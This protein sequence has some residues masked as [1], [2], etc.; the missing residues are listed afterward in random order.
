[1]LCTLCLSPFVREFQVK[2]TQCSNCGL[3]AKSADLL[4]DRMSEKS[5][6]EFHQN[7]L[8]DPGYLKFVDPMVS[9]VE[10]NCLQS[11]ELL[12]FGSGPDSAVGHRLRSLGFRV[13]KYDPFFHPVKASLLKTYDVLLVCEVVEHF[14][15]PLKDWELMHSLLK[16]KGQL[17]V[18][19]SLYP[20]DIKM[21]N[22]SYARD[23]THVSFY[24]EKTLQW[25]QD[26]FSF[27]KLLKL[28]KNFFVF[29][30][31]S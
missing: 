15:Q 1:M 20:S 24:S 19:T 31:L 22:W 3:V 30:G 10:K 14:H 28:E 26:R 6:Y 4:P 25:I 5:R 13:E 27:Q 29:Q 16:P 12:D 21:S 17:L 23:L 7:D 9:Y 18:M 8:N 2:Y 11:Q